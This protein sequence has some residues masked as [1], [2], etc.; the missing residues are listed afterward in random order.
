MSSRLPGT[1]GPDRAMSNAPSSSSGERRRTAA[2]QAIHDIFLADM[3]EYFQERQAA[4]PRRPFQI[5][6]L[7]HTGVWQAAIKDVSGKEAGAEEADYSFEAMTERDASGDTIVRSLSVRSLQPNI[8]RSD[9]QS[10]AEALQGLVRGRFGLPGFEVLVPR[11]GNSIV[12]AV[13]QRSRAELPVE[14]SRP[15]PAADTHPEQG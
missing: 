5:E 13:P 1:G 12:L 9:M 6:D 15:S 10:A 7:A 4:H 11:S 2:E 14:H 8:D 3:A